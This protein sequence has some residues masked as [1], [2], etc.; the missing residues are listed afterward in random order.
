MTDGGE[1]DSWGGENF[2]VSHTVAPG[3]HCCR[4][5]LNVILQGMLLDLC[6]TLHGSF[7]GE[8]FSTPG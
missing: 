3:C 8:M 7:L 2:S 1:S 6:D 5:K 4:Q